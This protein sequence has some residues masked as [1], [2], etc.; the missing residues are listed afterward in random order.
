MIK[1]ELQMNQICGNIYLE[2]YLLL[3]NDIVSHLCKIS[4]LED[5]WQD[6]NKRFLQDDAEESMLD[7][8]KALQ[9]EN[10]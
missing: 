5:L 3:Y 6:R 7:S 9:M 10:M 8:K 4:A 1:H 2:S